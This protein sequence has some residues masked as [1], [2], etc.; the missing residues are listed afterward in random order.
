MAAAR[1]HVGMVLLLAVCATTGCVHSV[2][3][4]VVPDAQPTAPSHADIQLAKKVVAK[5]AG[6]YGF[7][8][9]PNE[10]WYLS[11]ADKKSGANDQ[12][13]LGMPEAWLTHRPSVT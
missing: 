10:D 7:E 11:R 5:L 8:K 13:G 9:H 4:D 12:T 2:R 1:L 3:I 6:E